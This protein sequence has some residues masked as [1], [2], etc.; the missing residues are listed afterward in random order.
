MLDLK[1]HPYLTTEQRGVDQGRSIFSIFTNP[2]KGELDKIFRRSWQE[3]LSIPK[4][5]RVEYI[6]VDAAGTIV[7]PYLN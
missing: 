1:Q 2:K 5:S 7:D 4:E 6:Q 3:W